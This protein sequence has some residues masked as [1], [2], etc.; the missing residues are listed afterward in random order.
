M[1]T[2][3]KCVFIVMLCFLTTLLFVPCIGAQESSEKTPPNPSGPESTGGKVS[4]GNQP[5][6][7]ID[8]ADYDAGELHEGARIVHAFTIK[9]TGTAELVIEEVKAG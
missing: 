9:N 5:H 1:F 2:G 7:T 3:K 8:A 4:E 6:M